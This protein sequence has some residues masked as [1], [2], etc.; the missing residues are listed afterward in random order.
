[1]AGYQRS[2]LTPGVAW[3]CK[4]GMSMSAKILKSKEFG[5]LKRR[6]SAS[7]AKMRAEGRNNNDIRCWMI[8]FITGTDVLKDQLAFT[9]G[10]L[11]ELFDLTFD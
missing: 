2:I 5:D 4:R 1:M 9:A 11:S 10:Q 6:A 3:I 7:V 8:G